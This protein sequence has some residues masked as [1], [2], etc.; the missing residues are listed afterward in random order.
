MQQFH[1]KHTVMLYVIYRC[2]NLYK[3]FLIIYRIDCANSEQCNNSEISV[4]LQKHLTQ[5]F[6]ISPSLFEHMCR[7][8][9][10]D[11]LY[12]D[13]IYPCFREK[14]ITSG[15][16][17]DDFEKDLFVRPPFYWARGSP[18]KVNIISRRQAEELILLQLSIKMRIN[19]LI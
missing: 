12:T 2:Y 11:T 15:R 18:L 14:P 1:V 17:E 7:K 3:S 5:Q 8:S 4:S 9:A 6:R 16:K 19:R 10:T 13:T